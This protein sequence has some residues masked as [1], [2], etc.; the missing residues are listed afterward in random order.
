MGNSMMDDFILRMRGFDVCHFPHN[1]TIR[2]VLEDSKTKEKYTFTFEDN[3]DH[4]TGTL[5]EHCSNKLAEEW[6]AQ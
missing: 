3:H 5:L 2:C 4:R 1:M 6:P